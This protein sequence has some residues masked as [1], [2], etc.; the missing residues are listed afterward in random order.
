MRHQNQVAN[1][2][3]LLELRDHDKYEMSDTVFRIPVSRYTD[4]GTY[5][6]EMS[7]VF[8]GY[9]QLAGHACHVKEPGSFLLSDWEEFPFVVVRGADGVLRGFLNQCRHRGARLL[10]QASEKTCIK[11]FV[12]PFHNWVYE[13][14]GSLRSI[15]RDYMFPNLDRSQYGLV[16]LPVLERS[17]L[18]WIHPTPGAKIELDDFL[19]P[20]GDDIDH[21]GIGDLVSFRKSI[22]VRKANWKLLIKTYL[23][24]YHVPFLHRT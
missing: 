9:P 5:D 11:A 2:H 4:V 17:G 20:M 22:V 12:C 1:L 15:N 10:S 13:L 19:G 3:R 16:E 24:G 23:E 8:R 7:T 21:F 6:R 18:V 14:D